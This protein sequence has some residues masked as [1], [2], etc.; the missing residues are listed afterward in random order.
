MFFIIFQRLRVR[1]CV[2]TGF[3]AKKYLI[4]WQKKM[5]ICIELLKNAVGL[6]L[7][8]PSYISNV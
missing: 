5:L 7:K 6:I 4:I 1:L 2:N 8:K 3:K